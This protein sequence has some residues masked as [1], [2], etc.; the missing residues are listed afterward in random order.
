MEGILNVPDWS[1]LKVMGSHQMR[2]Q[3]FV[4]LAYLQTYF[5]VFI[6]EHTEPLHQISLSPSVILMVK[7]ALSPFRTPNSGSSYPQKR[8][9]GSA[10]QATA[11]VLQLL[12]ETRETLQGHNPKQEAY[13]GANVTTD[14]KILQMIKASSDTIHHAAGTNRMRRANDTMAVVDFSW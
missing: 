10:S 14:D 4:R 13:P 11:F 9:W 1:S 12:Y 7:S 6:R 3:S 5:C 2:R 8:R